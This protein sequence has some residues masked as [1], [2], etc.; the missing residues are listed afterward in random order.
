MGAWKHGS[1]EAWERGGGEAGGL[2]SGEAWE[3]E[4]GVEVKV[5]ST[6]ISGIQ[7]AISA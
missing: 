2:G 1:M 3:W 4:N 6:V 7:W 5:Q